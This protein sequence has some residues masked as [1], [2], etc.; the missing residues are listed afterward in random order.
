[1]KPDTLIGYKKCTKC[2]RVLSKDL[3]YRRPAATD[4]LRS[5]CKE[6]HNKFNSEY[7]KNWKKRN[8]EKVKIIQ[9]RS[10]KNYRKKYPERCK[11]RII[12][13]HAVRD[14]KIKKQPCI[15]CGNDKAE[16]HH[17]WVKKPLKVQWVCRIHH[18]R[19]HQL[20]RDF[21]CNDLEKKQEENKK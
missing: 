6:C 3:F 9:T 20:Y 14:G 21:N 8:P 10:T 2:K 7:N 13:N 4:G 5:W 19:L 12:L 16:A 18:S 17:E 11:A 1:M 15:V